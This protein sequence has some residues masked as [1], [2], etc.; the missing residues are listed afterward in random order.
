M[1]T[2][3]HHLSRHL[4]LTALAAFALLPG[5]D[6][7]EE[8]ADADAENY[9]EVEERSATIYGEPS[10]ICIRSADSSNAG[11][12]DTITLAWMTKGWG[13]SCSID[14]L[15]R[16][17]QKCCDVWHTGTYDPSFYS[18]EGAF[19]VWLWD[20]DGLKVDNVRMINEDG[21]EYKLTS[22]DKDGDH[23]H[24]NGCNSNGNDCN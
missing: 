19:R 23:L 12:D 6:A 1:K 16:N 22:F 10:E 13:W 8:D 3:I 21:V 11:T 4:L 14:G 5:C 24:C 9:S 15:G 7:V 17:E 20:S 2:S 18:F